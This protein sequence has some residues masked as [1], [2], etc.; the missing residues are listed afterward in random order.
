[1]K[2]RLLQWENGDLDTYWTEFK[3][4]VKFD[5]DEYQDWLKNGKKRYDKEKYE[6]WSN[7]R[8][9]QERGW[10]GRYQQRQ[11]QQQGKSIYDFF[12]LPTNASDKTV[13]ERVLAYQKT[14]HPDA[15]QNNTD[16]SEE[17][18]IRR[19][20]SFGE[21]MGDYDDLIK[22]MKKNIRAQEQRNRE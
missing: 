17:E 14:D 16:I 12:G 1:M 18:R 21:F 7:N 22:N 19:E 11:Q 8:E 4:R 5:E 10:Q 13:I 15:L 2:A 6:E 9:Q 20:K 3:H